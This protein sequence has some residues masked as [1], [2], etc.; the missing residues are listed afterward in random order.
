MLIAYQI[1]LITIFMHIYGL[2]EIVGSGSNLQ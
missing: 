2:P 1:S